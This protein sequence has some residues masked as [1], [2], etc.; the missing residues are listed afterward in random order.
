MPDL[1]V[2]GGLFRYLED[3]GRVHSRQ[4]DSDSVEITLPSGGHEPL[5]LNFPNSSLEPSAKLLR[6]AMNESSELTLGVG[7]LEGEPLLHCALAL[8]T[9]EGK[10]SIGVTLHGDFWL[11]H[12]RRLNRLTVPA[13]NR[14]AWLLAG[15]VLESIAD[16]RA[17]LN[18]ICM[19]LEIEQQEPGSGPGASGDEADTVVRW[20]PR[21]ELYG[22]ALPPCVRAA[23]ELVCAKTLSPALQACLPN[24][25]QATTDI[26]R[27]HDE[28]LE[29]ERTQQTATR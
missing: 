15:T 9:E 3:L 2:G 16:I 11:G 22:K 12:A 20:S 8:V 13:R 6:R 18:S 26:M 19:T 25:G 28:P 1:S 4:N 7:V 21:F 10:G 5:A 27:L 14:L 29:R 17:A 23:R 24:P